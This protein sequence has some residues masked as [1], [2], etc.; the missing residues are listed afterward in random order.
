MPQLD[1]V[2]M[3]TTYGGRLHKTIED[4]KTELIEVINQAYREGG[5]VII[6]AFAVERTQEII[7]T[8]ARAYEKGELPKEMP[9][10]LDSPLAIKST[11]IFREN[12]EFFDDTTKDLLDQG[13]TPMNLPTL[14]FT[15]TTEESQAVNQYQGSAV[16]IAG[17]GMAN[18]G[19][20]KHH[21]K[22][23]LWRPNC[24]VVI[25]GFQAQGTTGRQLVE[26][27]RKVK[28]FR[29]DVAVK[30]QVHT[31]GGFSAHADQS[32]LLQWL[33]HLA[34]PGLRVMLIHGEESGMMAFKALA[35]EKFPQVV[36]HAPE[37][38]EKLELPPS[39]EVAPAPLLKAAGLKARLARLERR[40]TEPGLD[41]A[42]LSRLEE[43]LEAAER[44]AGLQ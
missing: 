2:F 13:L 33:S 23:N 12:P 11:V 1:T 9:I 28:I 42:V 44:E 20:V 41:E 8:L 19:R 31:I 7:Y 24:H 36:F 17:S 3:E 43:A 38:R 26:G 27:A 35:E 10:F 4:S 39:G 22:H 6:P 5:K 40:L 18:A 34:R 37:L 21:L 30:A 15:P 16:I 25:V 29:E 14:K 32:E